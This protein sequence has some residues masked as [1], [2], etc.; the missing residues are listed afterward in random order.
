[1][2]PSYRGL[3]KLYP[4]FSASQL[5]YRVAQKSYEAGNRHLTR[6]LLRRSTD[7]R[8]ENQAEYLKQN[9]CDKSP[10]IN[11]AFFFFFF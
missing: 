3:A 7:D 9:I 4:C 5:G 6:L 11:V 2:I 10:T 8:K 1:M